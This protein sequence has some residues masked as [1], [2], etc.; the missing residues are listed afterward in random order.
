LKFIQFIK[1]N[2]YVYISPTNTLK[3]SKYLNNIKNE[4][5]ILISLLYDSKLGK[6]AKFPIKLNVC[7]YS[8]IMWN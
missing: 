7:Q 2:E 5:I 8:I 3:F 1:S 6:I 4:C